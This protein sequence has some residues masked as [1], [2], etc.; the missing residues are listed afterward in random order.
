MTFS[1]ELQSPQSAK[2]F[3][4]MICTAAEETDGPLRDMIASAATAA[5]TSSQLPGEMSLTRQMS[6]SSLGQAGSS[7]GQALI[8]TEGN[9]GAADHELQDYLLNE[10]GGASAGGGNPAKMH[11]L[12]LRLAGR[13]LLNNGSFPAPDFQRQVQ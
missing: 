4:I 8:T 13:R 6:G 5:A 11:S 9:V 10:G 12:Y 7:L 3:R 2:L 1:V